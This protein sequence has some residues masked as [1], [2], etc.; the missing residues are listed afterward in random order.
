MIEKSGISVNYI[1]QWLSIAVAMSTRTHAHTKRTQC[2]L[3][4]PLRNTRTHIYTPSYTYSH[5]S[6]CAYNRNELNKVYWL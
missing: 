6:A 2:M 4:H 3:A 5:T 1:Q